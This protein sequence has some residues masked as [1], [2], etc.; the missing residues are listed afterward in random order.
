MEFMRL[1]CT[2]SQS[3]PL[4]GNS[5]SYF[6]MGGAVWQ[7]GG[8]LTVTFESFQI[9]SPQ[10]VQI[11]VLADAQWGHKVCSSNSMMSSGAISR[12]QIV[13]ITGCMVYLLMNK[14]SRDLIPGFHK[15]NMWLFGFY[16]TDFSIF[17]QQ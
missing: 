12:S 8:K 6:I 4:G 17:S 10:Q 3:I 13:Q 14:N 16:F 7:C 11:I 1:S 15:D 2:P 5:W 9:L